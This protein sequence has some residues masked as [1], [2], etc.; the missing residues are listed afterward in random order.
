MWEP[1]PL[2]TLWAS[3]ACNRDI[4]TY[5]TLLLLLLCRFRKNKPM[6]LTWLTQDLRFSQR[7]LWRMPSSGMWRCV[8]SFV[9]SLHGANNCLLSLHRA[10]YIKQ[11]YRLTISYY[12][13]LWRRC[14]AD[15]SPVSGDCSVCTQTVL[16]I[17]QRF[18]QHLH[19]SSPRT[20]PTFLFHY[21]NRLVYPVWR[22]VRTSPP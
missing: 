6:E 16:P 22:R 8:D 20:E 12:T 1:R 17:F 14:S 2:G 3:T 18:I 5:F 7:W 9:S 4:F 19:T 15:T 10:Y 13:R 21:N 11:S